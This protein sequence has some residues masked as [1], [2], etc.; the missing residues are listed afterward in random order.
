LR[1]L[2]PGLGTTTGTT[3]VAFTWSAPSFTGGSAITGY[4][5]Y[6]ETPFG[7]DG[8]NTASFGEVP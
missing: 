1:T 7:L 8:S 5:V 4:D 2:P 6:E 3:T